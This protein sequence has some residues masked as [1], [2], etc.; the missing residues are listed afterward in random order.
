MTA[1]VPAP[2]RAGGRAGGRRAVMAVNVGVPGAG[3]HAR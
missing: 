3:P 1:S 2:P